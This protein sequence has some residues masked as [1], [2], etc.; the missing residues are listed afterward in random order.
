MSN[1]IS[2]KLERQQSKRIE[3]IEKALT[4]KTQALTK[5]KQ[6]LQQEQALNKKNARYKVKNEALPV[7]IKELES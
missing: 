2:T 6:S 4:A 5:S 3:H 7:Q 1:K